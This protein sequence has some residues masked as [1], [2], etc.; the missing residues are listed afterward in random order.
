VLGGL[1]A[2]KL[3]P[4]VDAAW[5]LVQGRPAGEPVPIEVAW[6]AHYALTGFVCALAMAA[7]ALPWAVRW[8]RLPLR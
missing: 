7:I 3:G 4:H 2:W 6:S 5:G 1:V 8:L